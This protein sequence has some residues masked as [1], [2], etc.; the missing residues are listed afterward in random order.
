MKC[1]SWKCKAYTGGVLPWLSLLVLV[2]ILRGP[3]L[4]FAGFTGSSQFWGKC[5]PLSLFCHFPFFK[6]VCLWLWVFLAVAMEWNSCQRVGK[7]GFLEKEGTSPLFHGLLH[8]CVTNCEH[9]SCSTSCTIF[10][11]LPKQ[12]ITE[13]YIKISFKKY[14]P[15]NC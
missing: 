3:L 11:L 6:R 5:H 13:K 4:G 9:H 12:T 1:Q 2:P 7:A 8:V 10:C 14:L 15:S